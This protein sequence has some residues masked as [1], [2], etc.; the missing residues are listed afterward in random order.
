[1]L[2]CMLR[3]ACASVIFQVLPASAQI[4]SEPYVEGQMLV[5]F[6]PGAAATD[7]IAIR[8]ALLSPTSQELSIVPDLELVQTPLDAAQATAVLANNPNVLYIEPDFLLQP[9]EVVPD[10]TYFY[11]Q[12]GMHNTGQ[13]LPVLNDPGIVDADID[14]PEAWA[15][16]ASLV[17]EP[18]VVA[19]IDSGAMLDH[20]DLAA[21][22]WVN[23]DEIPGN[24]ID[25]DNNG[26]ID[27]INGWDFFADDNDPTDES[28]HG[29]HVAGTIAAIPN[30]ALGVAGICGSCQI[31]VLRFLGSNSGSTADAI[32][33][34]G[35]AAAK[36]VKISNNSWSGPTYSQALYDAIEAAAGQEHVFVTS[37]GNE[38]EDI[39]FFPRYPASYDLANIISVAA[40]TNDDQLAD[41]SSFGAAGVDL[42]APGLN[43]V[44]L[45]NVGY[46]AWK[47]GTSMASPHVAGVAALLHSYFPLL[48]ADAGATK[49]ILLDTVR[50]LPAL[51]ANT[52]TGGMLNAFDAVLAA[53]SYQPAPELAPEPGPEDPT[54]IPGT[55]SGLS[56]LD[57]ED[58]SARLDWSL[59]PYASQY[60]IEREKYQTQGR[61]ADTWTRSESFTVPSPPFIDPVGSS[62]V[63][64]RIAAAN[65]AGTSATSAWIYVTVTRC[66]WK[67]GC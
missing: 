30:N 55:P 50:P 65:S 25:D 37:A 51:S 13:T 7:R 31:M 28:S 57:L 44:S 61:Y 48:A 22:L 53:Q 23:P 35:Y 15:E 52:S 32:L 14:M 1:M 11:I 40:T 26:F 27:D 66:H 5:R 24:G 41:F 67:K 12:W 39:D 59:V 18:V 56:A 2:R 62:D 21:N 20:P 60:I 43:V 17:A 33:A 8:G 19:V 42:G 10:D 4:S 64:Y 46:Y 29:S 38:S 6:A 49:S 36:G 9:T 3:L 47:S 58:G 54:P 45:N 63:R 16:V 34:L